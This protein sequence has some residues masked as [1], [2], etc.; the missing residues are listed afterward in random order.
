[1]AS[2]LIN[3]L[4]FPFYITLISL[5]LDLCSLPSKKIYEWQTLRGHILNIWMTQ[6]T[7]D[8]STQSKTLNCRRGRFHWTDF[9]GSTNRMLRFRIFKYSGSVL[10]GPVIHMLKYMI[11]LYESSLIK[12]L[13]SCWIYQVHFGARKIKLYLCHFYFK[14]ILRLF[15][16]MIFDQFKDFNCF[17]KAFQKNKFFKSNFRDVWLVSNRLKYYFPCQILIPE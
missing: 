7:R 10:W 3:C 1:M 5:S 15:Q 6:T 16:I 17:S 2:T 13:N 9:K 11:G 4:K 12:S 14:S 8:T